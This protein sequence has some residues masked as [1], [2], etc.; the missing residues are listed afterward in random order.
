MTSTA[1]T[2]VTC[3]SFADIYALVGPE[4]TGFDNW[5]DAA[6][7]AKELGSNTTFP[8]A[9]LVITGPGEESGTFDSFVEIVITPI[10]TEREKDATTRPDYTS[11]ANDNVIIE[12]ITGNP[13]SFGWVGL[14]FAEENEGTVTEIEVAKDPNGTCVGPSAETV[15][16]SSYPISRPLFIYVNKA[17][18]A[19]NPA[20]RRLR[21]LLPRPGHDRGSPQDRPVCQPPGDRARCD[22]VCLAVGDVA[23]HSFL[24]PTRSAGPARRARPIRHL[25]TN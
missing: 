9:P 13:T 11:S 20:D 18:A 5:S 6:P 7:L 14:A 17:K 3:L 10:A 8:D 25:R 23:S 21:R 2:A 4:S 19:A 22:A 15:S 24:V 1:N 12:G 16:D